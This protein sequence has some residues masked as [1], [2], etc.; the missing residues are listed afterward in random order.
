[1]DD[2]PIIVVGSSGG[3]VTSRQSYFSAQA[4]SAARALAL[5]EDALRAKFARNANL[6]NVAQ[7][8]EQGGD[9]K[10][11]ARLYQRL[12]LSRPRTE[13]TTSAQTRLSQIQSAALS[14]LETLESELNAASGRGGVPSALQSTRVDADRVI[15]VFAELDQLAIEYAGVSSIETKIKERTEALRTKRQFATILQEPVAN[16]LWTLGQKHENEQKRCCAFLVYEQAANL[17]PA[18]SAELARARLRQ[19]EADAAIVAE[20]SKCKNL[21]LCHEKYERAMSIKSSLPDRARE[22]LSQ[23]LEVA[24]PDTSIHKAAREQIAMLR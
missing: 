19:L 2:S 22:Y 10:V 20:A 18:P 23:I 24:T 17:V 7:Q 12:A 11:A 14:K 21:Q 9:E 4:S 1:V 5:R 6:W 13:V 15:K 3:Y 16:Q 8:A